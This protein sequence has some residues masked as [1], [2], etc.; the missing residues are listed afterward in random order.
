MKYCKRIACLALCILLSASLLTAC[1][2]KNPDIQPMEAEEAVNFSYDY[3]GG[4]DVMPIIGFNGAQTYTYSTNG[5]SI[6]ESITDEFMQMVKECGVNTISSNG[7]DFATYPELTKK[8]LDLGEKHGVGIYVVD[9]LISNSLGENALS[10]QELDERVSNY[11]DHPACV[12]VYVKDEPSSDVYNKHD[13]HRMALYSPTF[14]NFKKC[15]LYTF[16]AYVTGY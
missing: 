11:I 8:L 7:A 10:L 5:Q 9:S 1:S 16:T 12:G 3:I 14:Q 2:G 6:P 4:T 15:L 13:P